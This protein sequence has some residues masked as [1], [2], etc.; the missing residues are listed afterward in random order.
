MATLARTPNF[1]S[2]HHRTNRRHPSSN[3][4]NNPEIKRLRLELQVVRAKLKRTQNAT[5]LQSICANLL[6]NRQKIAE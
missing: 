6:N 4:E 5:F 1:K 2:I 3:N